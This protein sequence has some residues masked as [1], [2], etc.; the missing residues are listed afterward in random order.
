VHEK[1][2]GEYLVKGALETEK[3]THLCKGTAETLGTRIEDRRKRM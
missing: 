1:K 2:R 3:N